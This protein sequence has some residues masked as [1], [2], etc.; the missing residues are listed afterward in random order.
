MMMHMR[1][2]LDVTGT[3]ALAW[4]SGSVFARGARNTMLQQSP[5]DTSLDDL[6]V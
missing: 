1:V 5:T 2:I 6:R 3:L 4:Y